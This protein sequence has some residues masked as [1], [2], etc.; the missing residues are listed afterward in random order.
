MRELRDVLVRDRYQTS[1]DWARE[2]GVY[3]EIYYANLEW[4]AGAPCG[5]EEIA[6]L[7]EINFEELV[8]VH[9]L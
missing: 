2:D 9:L 8:E 7:I 5:V 4:I 1:Y 3:W 6:D